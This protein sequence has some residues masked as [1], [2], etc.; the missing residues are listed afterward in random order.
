[1]DR[2][3]RA[4]LI[5]VSVF[6]VKELLGKKPL[7]RGRGPCLVLLSPTG[8]CGPNS[9]PVP[10]RARLRPP[11]LSSPRPQLRTP[12]PR[13]PDS[14]PASSGEQLRRG[15]SAARPAG[16]R[17]GLSSSRLAGAQLRQRILVGGP[18]GRRRILPQG[19]GA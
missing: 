16:S 2:Q 19:V 14:L 9:L 4:A 7:F 15:V 6:K 11:L 8:L 3:G 18:A 10:Q 13:A 12:G 5:F 17:R 1:M